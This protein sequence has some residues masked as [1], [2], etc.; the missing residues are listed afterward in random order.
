MKPNPTDQGGEAG[1]MVLPIKSDENKGR[2]RRISPLCPVNE[3]DP[4]RSHCVSPFFC[5]NCERSA[6]TSSLAL[7]I[8]L[9][10]SVRMD[11]WMPCLSV[12]VCAEMEPSLAELDQ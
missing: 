8:C 1:N 12:C 4:S 11:G 3:E 9:S 5:Q 2:T 10:D 6:T 7:P